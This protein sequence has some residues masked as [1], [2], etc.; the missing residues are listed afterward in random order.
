M[1]RNLPVLQLGIIQ[2]CHWVWE[3]TLQFSAE[4]LRTIFPID[5]T[6]WQSSIRVRILHQ[7]SLSIIPITTKKNER[8]CVNQKIFLYDAQWI[9][10]ITCNTNGC[11]NLRVFFFC[12]IGPINPTNLII[13]HNIIHNTNSSSGKVQRDIKLVNSYLLY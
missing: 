5:S 12:S 9:N 7:I 6:K 1:L 10:S 2:A 4:I 8:K 11:T 13:I 3:G